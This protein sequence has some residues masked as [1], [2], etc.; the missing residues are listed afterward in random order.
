MIAHDWFLLE[1]NDLGKQC[2]LTLFHG[3]TIILKVKRNYFV[4]I[5]VPCLLDMLFDNAKDVAGRK[6]NNLAQSVILI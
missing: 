6:C 2:V 1:L 5:L 4:N 3:E